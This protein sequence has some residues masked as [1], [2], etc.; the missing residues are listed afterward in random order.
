MTTCRKPSAQAR[1]DE[2]IA[3]VRAAAD[4]TEDM[5]DNARLDDAISRDLRKRILRLVAEYAAAAHGTKEFTPGRSPVPVSGKVFDA[6]D[7]QS[8]VA[9]S[10]DFWLTAGRFNDAFESHLTNLLTVKHALTVNS[11]SSANLLAV[12]A[13]TSPMLGKDALKPG[14]EVVTVA[15]GFPTTV[16]PII[17]NGMTPVFVDVELPTY[18]MSVSQ[19]KKAITRKTKAI[20]AAHTL[21][22]P[23][24]LDGICGI[25][26]DN[27][28]FLIEDCC[29]A[30]GS[31]YHGRMAGSFGDISTFSFYPAHHITTGEGGAVASNDKTLT[32]IMESMRDWG[33][34]CHC[35]TGK[36]NTCGRRFSMKLG[37]L[38]YGYDH[39]YTY[40]N[41]GY[42]LKMTDMQAAVGL[43]QIE[44]LDEFI[45]IRRRNYRHLFEGLSGLQD[46]LMLPES[47][48]NSDPSWFG[49]PI[50][51][52]TKCKIGRN[53]LVRELE[54]K[55]IGTRLL[56]GGNLLRQPYFKR[57]PHRTV[58]KLTNT[59]TIMRDTFWIGVFPGLTEE[60][61]DYVAASLAEC[62]EDR[63]T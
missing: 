30:L 51:L 57:L 1:G 18:N 34:D 45:R 44:H 7:L 17:Q 5:L 60:M 25:A 16:N 48:R 27:D 38:P 19:V 37:D 54:R 59:D 41:L 35:P 15:A 46:K 12:S 32:R 62:L 53:Q 3:R 21:G 4:H 28:L 43:A 56:F 8:L 39:K 58:G 24:D 26:E 52:K 42:N 50:T 47:T 40:S 49:F 2:D 63:A 33:R 55:N 31:T 10:L 9:A 20:I 23:F 6:S 13:L 22:N 61:L 14:D 29:D 11:G 36:D